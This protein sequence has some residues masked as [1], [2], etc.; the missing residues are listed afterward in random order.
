MFWK[1]KA[2]YAKR[3]TV[4][5]WNTA[6][7]AEKSETIDG[8]VYNYLEILQDMTTKIDLKC[9]IGTA[10]DGYL[11]G[12]CKMT[13]GS[14]EMNL[15][16]EASVPGNCNKIYEEYIV[17]RGDKFY[18][19]NYRRSTNSDHPHPYSTMDGLILKK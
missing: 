5:C 12:T 19:T 1:D 10:H 6:Y 8:T 17:H 2:E 13:I 15:T 4:F 11:H 16:S 14:T 9:G 7:F 18:I 3:F